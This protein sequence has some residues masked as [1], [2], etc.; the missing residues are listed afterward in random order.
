MRKNLLLKTIAG[1]FA[2]VMLMYLLTTIYEYLK[3]RGMF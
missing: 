3:A 1:F 2:G